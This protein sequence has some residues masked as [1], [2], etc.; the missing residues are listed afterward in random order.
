MTE[1][2]PMIVVGY[3][4]AMQHGLDLFRPANSVIFVDEPDVAIGRDV[5]AHMAGSASARELITFEYQ[6]AGAAD[7]FFNRYRDLRPSAVIPGVEYAVPFAARIAER[8]GVPGAGLGAAQILRDKA[9]LRTVAR[10][11]GIA[12]P[13]SQPVGS[14]AAVRAFMAEEDGPIVLKPANRQASVGTKIL[15][16]GAEVDEAWVECTDQDEGVLVP[17]RGL[18][19]QMLAEQY[20]VGDE[21]SVEMV[22]RDGVPLFQNVTAKTVY[23]GPR[24]IELG[25]IVPADISPAQTESLLVET[26]RVLDA[27]GFG[28]GFVHCEWI[29]S[30]GVAFLVECAGR[31]PGDGIM[32]LIQKAWQ[33]EVAQ[34]YIAVMEGR[35]APEEVPQAAPRGAA[36]WFLHVEPGEVLSVDGVE[37]AKAV[38]DV[39]TVVVG[40]E[41][42]G[43]VHE[44]RSSWD[45]IALVTAC[46]RDTAE[47]LGRAQEAIKAITVKVQPLAAGAAQG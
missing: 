20:V 4:I 23:P 41:P 12:N 31:M 14:P 8:Y 37:A 7:A 45:R 10:S 16:D 43:H 34:L 13:R 9:L 47:A 39:V 33:F 17:E 25:H 42:G 36:V 22:V 30:D 27:V 11:A 21:F 28:T 15:F 5:K 44:L 1:H 40:A 35:P 26:G 18:P 3:T 24:P 29:V 32:E 38:P 46:S 2:R 6:L 19:L